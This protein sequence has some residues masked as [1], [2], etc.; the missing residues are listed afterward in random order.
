MK[1]NLKIINLMVK[2]KYIFIRG[3]KIYQ[4][5]TFEGDFEGDRFINGKI[6]LKN[7]DILNGPNEIIYANGDN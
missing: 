2:A 5:G 4:N 1:E 6:T 3:K 7:G